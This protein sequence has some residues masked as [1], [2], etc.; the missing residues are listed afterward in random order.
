MR[1]TEG[2]ALLA[3][4]TLEDDALLDAMAADPGLIERSFVFTS[5][6]VRLC[7]PAEA[8]REILPG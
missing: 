5:K 7:R 8:L 3:D 6:G 1:R 2:A 4:P